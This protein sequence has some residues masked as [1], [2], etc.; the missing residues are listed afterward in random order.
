MWLGP[1]RHFPDLWRMRS[2]PLARSLPDNS[3]ALWMVSRGKLAS[4]VTIQM[5]PPLWPP[6]S[7][8]VT[9]LFHAFQL[10]RYIPSLVCLVQSFIVSWSPFEGHLSSL[11]SVR[12]SLTTFSSGDPSH[13]WTP[14]VLCC[15]PR[16]RNFFSDAFCI[17]AP[18]WG[19]RR[20]CL[21]GGR[22]DLWPSWIPWALTGDVREWLSDGWGGQECTKEKARG[23]KT[24][25]I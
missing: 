3:T 2:R 16:I 4:L 14:G 20:P 8:Y 1:E 5:T 24:R 9:S 25:S 11:F 23:V 21:M 10:Q 13:L 18:R 7:L 17:L 6:C 15:F 19:G 22:G 12:L